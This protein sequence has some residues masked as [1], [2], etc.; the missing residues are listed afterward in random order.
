MPTLTTKGAR[1]AYSD[2]GPPAGRQPALPDAP[3]IV[4]GHGLLF[5][6]RMF[7]AQI[8][9]L[10]Q[11]HRCVAIDWRGQGASPP[12]DGGYDMDTLSLDAVA[13]IESLDVGPVHYVGLS[14]GGFVGQRV[15]ARRPDLIRSLILLDTS[16]EA[17]TPSAVRQDKLLANVF[18]VAGLGPV[19]KP[20]LK[21][22]FGPSFLADPRSEAVIEEWMSQ[23]ARNDRGAI[24]RAVLGV[25]DR[26]PILAELG[27]ITAPTLVVV[28]EP[29][30][31]TPPG[32]ARTIVA[33]I[34]GA[35]LEI[36]SDSGHSS[37]IE[38]PEVLTSL[39]E[40]FVLGVESRAH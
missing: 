29:D 2:T 35:R 21:L 15:A 11:T 14:M 19:R 10:R 32:R 38:Q 30:A 13:L 39:I 23:V 37:T 28:G 33:A 36:V 34:A 8:D 26:A 9:R 5:S 17:E 40:S 12:A 7:T 24:R 27:A 4:F 16:A 18:R 31:P 3:T 20:V 1:I 25:A 22:M 6:G